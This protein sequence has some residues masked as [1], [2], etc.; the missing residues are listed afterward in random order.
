MIYGYGLSVNGVSTARKH[1]CVCRSPRGGSV[2]PASWA[3]DDLVIQPIVHGKRSRLHERRLSLAPIH[4]RSPTALLGQRGHRS[5]PLPQVSQPRK[6]AGTM[7]RLHKEKA[8]PR[9]DR[10]LSGA[11]A[12]NTLDSALVKPTCLPARSHEHPPQR[13]RNRDQ[14]R[15]PVLWPSLHIDNRQTQAITS[16][17]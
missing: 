16:T 17:D 2:T 4:A 7:V 1:D 15:P 14:K 6:P 11:R 12:R 9:H 5:L 10:S 3:T 13:H 8:P